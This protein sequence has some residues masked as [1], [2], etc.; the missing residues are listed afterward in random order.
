MGEEIGGGWNFK[1]LG[2]G[3]YSEIFRIWW[4]GDVRFKFLLQV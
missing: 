1:V 2:L 3:W 4:L